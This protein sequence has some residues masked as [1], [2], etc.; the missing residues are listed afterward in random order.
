M[1]FGDK[2]VQFRFPV[3]KLSCVLK[4]GCPSEN[5][6]AILESLVS[7]TASWNHVGLPQL[8]NCSPSHMSFFKNFSLLLAFKNGVG[9]H[10]KTAFSKR[11]SIENSANNF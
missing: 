4:S 11:I 1:S 8:R 6:S 3:I 7:K 5:N 2:S 9:S 10:S